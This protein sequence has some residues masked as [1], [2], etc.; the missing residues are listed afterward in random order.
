M[1]LET[2]TIFACFFNYIFDL[3][4]EKLSSPFYLISEIHKT[5]L[6]ILKL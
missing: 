1:P 3:Q 5:Q 6:F 2:L 4:L